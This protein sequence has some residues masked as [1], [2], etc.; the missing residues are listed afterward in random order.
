VDTR[1]RASLTQ[2]LFGQLQWIFNY[3]STPA[4]GSGEDDSLFLLTLGW[5]F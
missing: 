4:P 3:D 5:K 1:L 2:R